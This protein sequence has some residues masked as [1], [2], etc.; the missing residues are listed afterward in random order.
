MKVGATMLMLSLVG[1]Q[2]MPNLLPARFLE[3]Q[4]LM[5]I[6]TAR[7]EPV[8]QRLVKM[9]PNAGLLP[10]EP[11]DILAIQEAIHQRLSDDPQRDSEL[12]FNLT[13]GTKAMAIAA[14]RLAET[15]QSSFVY[16]Q[17]EGRQ[18]LLHHYTWDEARQ[19]KLNKTTEILGVVSI[20]DYVRAHTGAFHVTGPSKDTGGAFELALAD[21]L[22]QEFDEVEVGVK[23]SG[24]LDADLVVRSGNRVAVIEAKTGKKAL[25]KG[26]IDQLNTIAGPEYLGIYTA[27][28]LVID[29]QWDGT[30]SNLRE[31]AEARNIKV[32]QLPGYRRDGIIIDD[33]KQQLITALQARL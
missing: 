32:V 29:Q 21:I 19:P 13:G 6:H 4:S 22:R 18:S 8:S 28:F 33:E 30:R 25:Q 14:Y 3:P 11:Y 26:G 27:K 20:E 24:A 5:L 10:V 15:M 2:P 9:L 31:L 23:L 17:S 7:T 12:V 16:F 1:E